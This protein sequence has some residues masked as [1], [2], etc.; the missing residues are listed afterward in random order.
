MTNRPRTQARPRRTPNSPK[1]PWWQRPTT[2]IAALVL[3]A[4]TVAGIAAANSGGDETTPQT[5][6]AEAL[7]G[8][9]PPLTNPDPA[10]GM[11]AP[12][13]SAQTLAG[14]RVQFLHDDGTARLY[15]FFA[16]WCPVCQDELPEGTAWLEEHSLPDGVEVVAVST[17]VDSTR[18][19]YPP[20]DWFARE[21]WPAT[22]LLDDEQSSLATGFGLTAFP[23]WVAVDA[24]GTVIARVS[25][26]LAETDFLTL[27]DALGDP[28]R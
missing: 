22:V 1:P 25:G 21:E 6:F 12:T 2:W 28:A 5:A 19:N 23:Y 8:P 17:A 14:E 27:I 16:H 3:I 24:D 20:S 10:V 15:G 9:L 7:G 26:R 13:I 4:A 11:N 18:G